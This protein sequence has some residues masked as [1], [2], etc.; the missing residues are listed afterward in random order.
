V[1]LIVWSAGQ[2]IAIDD[3]KDYN[4]LAVGLVERGEFGYTPGQPASLRPPL[5]PAM[6]AGIYWLSGGENHTA[7]RVV[8]AVLGLLAALV[9]YR[10]AQGMYGQK[11]GTGPICAL[12]PFSVPVLAAAAVC[13]Y[14]SLLFMGTQILTEVLF[15]FLVCLA[16]LLMQRVLDGFADQRSRAA[17]FALVGFGVVLGLGALTR[18]VLWLFPP[19]LMVFLVWATRR[20]SGV[21]PGDLRPAVS[22]GTEARAE[23]E[24]AVQSGH[25]APRDEDSSRGARRLRTAVQSRHLAPRDE[26]SSRGARRLRT[27]VQS[28]HLAPR[29]EDSSRGARRLRWDFGRRV[30]M[31]LVPV[32]AFCAVIAPWAVRN[33]RLHKTF[34]TIDVMGGRNM[35]MGNY[36]YTPMYRSWDAIS[37]S[38][39]KAWY[40]L[41]AD[42]HPGFSRLTQGQLD[43]LAMKRGIKFVLANPGLTAQRDLVKFLNFWQLERTVAAGFA[44]GYWGDA[45][46]WVKLAVAAIVAGSYAAAMLL[47]IFGFVMTRPAD[48]RLHWFLLLLVAFICAAHTAVF[49]HERYRLPLMPIVMIYAAAAAVHARAIWQRR[50]TLAFWLATGLCTLMVASWAWELVWVEWERIGKLLVA[51]C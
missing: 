3:A 17:F 34:T 48:V 12:S 10:L 9:V 36:E 2:P 30:G 31:A 13:F 5:Y 4:A 29:D 44:R 7:V 26:D 32:L 19:F 1:L 39:E 15:T 41:L 20:R 47:G 21:A 27:A 18:S 46:R 50:R 24:S 37:V 23:R 43:K 6:V 42:E 35:M 25:L 33:T 51:S 14:P 16:C 40:R 11:Q 22:A 8:Q 38:G 28:G 49:A 45:P